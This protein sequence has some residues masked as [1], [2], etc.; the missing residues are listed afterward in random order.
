[1]QRGGFLKLEDGNAG[2][3]ELLQALRDILVF[4]G[5]MADIKHY[6]EMAA[7]RDMSFRD[8]NLRELGE[9]FGRGAGIKMVGEIIDRLV[10]GLEEAIGLRLERKRDG[11]PGARFK[12]D[13]MRDDPHDVVGIARDHVAARSPAA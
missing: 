11:A 9:L 1:M 12:A 5:L 6:A 7:Q 3:D 13:E 4:H 2:I 8:R 10:G